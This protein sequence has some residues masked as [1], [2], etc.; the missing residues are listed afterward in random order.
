MLLGQRSV[1]SGLNTETYSLLFFD[2]VW[3]KALTATEGAT[4][5]RAGLQDVTDY[6]LHRRGQFGHVIGGKMNDRHRE[7]PLLR[8]RQSRQPR[9]QSR[10]CT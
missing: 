3:L 8:G 10:S 1:S 7:P 9:D 4:K 6:A 2:W 5:G